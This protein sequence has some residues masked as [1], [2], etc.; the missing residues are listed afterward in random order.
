MSNRKLNR[1][2]KLT[3]PLATLFSEI[4]RVVRELPSKDLRFIVK[5]GSLFTET[6]CWWASFNVT[7]IA[8]EMAE[9]ELKLRARANKHN[10][11]RRINQQPQQ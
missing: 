9:D 7:P 10:K 2:K 8:S 1:L 5:N 3:H 6:N 11:K 4:E